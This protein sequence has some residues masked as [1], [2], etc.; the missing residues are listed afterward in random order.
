MARLVEFGRKE[1]T[2]DGDLMVGDC[3]M[4][5]G[6][7][8]ESSWPLNERVLDYQVPVGKTFRAESL[9]VAAY[10]PNWAN[11]TTFTGGTP[12]TVSLLHNGSTVD[13]YR[14]QYTGLY[15]NPSGYAH[16]ALWDPNNRGSFEFGDGI[17]LSAGSS[18]SLAIA[19]T[20]PNSTQAPTLVTASIMGEANGA[21][22]IV[23]GAI[24]VRSTAVTTVVSCAASTDDITV[25]SAI[26]QFWVGW[27]LLSLLQVRVNGAVWWQGCNLGS[28]AGVAGSTCWNINVPLFSALFNPGDRIVVGAHVMLPMGQ[29]CTATLAGDEADVPA[30]G[31]TLTRRLII[32]R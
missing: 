14:C 11:V 5:A 20:A 2:P 25:H 31:L 32:R 18:E 1:W 17:V 23:R 28:P 12:V 10:T 3:G 16:S 29:V 9:L 27:P 30:G 19:A 6:D 24:V 4:R 26:F 15:S 22:F 21:P 8:M 13:T 7:M